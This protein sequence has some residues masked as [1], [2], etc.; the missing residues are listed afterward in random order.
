MTSAEL[1]EILDD[2]NKKIT[3][4]EFRDILSDLKAE[5]LIKRL[6]NLDNKKGEYEIL[7]GEGSAYQIALDLSEHIGEEQANENICR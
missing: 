6:K 2:E 3:L 1:H 7:Y 4:K 5:S